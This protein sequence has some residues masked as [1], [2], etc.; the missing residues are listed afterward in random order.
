M[1]RL[2]QILLNLLSNSL[3]YTHKNGLIKIIVSKTK[4]NDD[5]FIKIAVQD[6]GL[7]INKNDQKNLFKLFSQIHNDKNLNK[8]SIGLGLCICKMI[9]KEFNGNIYV[10][11][12]YG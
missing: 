12:E 5:E 1:M 7:G 4:K 9:S 2:Q 10:L 8:K 3:K 6:N 11:S